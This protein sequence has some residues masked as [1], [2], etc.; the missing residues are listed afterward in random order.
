M[1]TIILTILAIVSAL[2]HMWGEYQGPDILI[3][4]E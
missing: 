3:T 4:C 2:I 1:T